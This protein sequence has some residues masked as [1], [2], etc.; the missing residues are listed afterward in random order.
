MRISCNTSKLEQ[1]LK[2]FHEQ[3]VY[4]LQGMVKKFSYWVTVSATNYTPLGD[5]DRYAS[6]YQL[7]EERY[8]LEPKEGFARGSWQVSLDGSLDVQELYGVNSNSAAVDAAITNLMNYSL[9]DTLL[10]GNTGPYIQKLENNYSDKTRGQG[11]MQPT[12][13]MITNVYQLD[14]DTYYRTTEK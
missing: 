11:I 13:E 2:K 12:I 8:G 5:S 10:I 3:A 1:S 9:G 14:L 4:K 7:R 6:L